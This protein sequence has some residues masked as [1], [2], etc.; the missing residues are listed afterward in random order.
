MSA[1]IATLR[2]CSLPLLLLAL[3]G[4][5]EGSPTGPRTRAM[6]GTWEATQSVAVPE[7]NFAFSQTLRVEIER[8]EGSGDIYGHVD[9]PGLGRCALS[10]HAS[11]GAVQL[12]SYRCFPFG[13]ACAGPTAVCAGDR[14]LSLC[15]TAT[16]SSVHVV[17]AGDT[18]IGS[19]SGS[20]A[21]FDPATGERVTSFHTE[22]PVTFRRLG[23]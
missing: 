6:V 22:A 2:V 9:Y 1:R 4:C 23:D 15:P 12:D 21:A 19:A 10:G 18:G 8:G 3:S 17:F 14:R 7:C 16:W 11:G 13:Y 20:V 5:D